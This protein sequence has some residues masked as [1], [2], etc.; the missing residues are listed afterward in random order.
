MSY[1][2]HGTYISSR[3]GKTATTDFG[4]QY[5]SVKKTNPASQ[6]V[7]LSA[8]SP[9]LPNKRFLFIKDVR[10]KSSVKANIA[11]QT[12]K[13]DGVT[14]IEDFGFETEAGEIF[15]FDFFCPLRIPVGGSIKVILNE[16]SQLTGDVF[17]YLH[18]WYEEANVD[19]VVNG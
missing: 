2:D 10:V 4:P 12:F 14:K 3:P 6:E 17:V 16:A 7:L 5:L 19:D 13:A 8:A 11:I 1:S 15:S 18:G 9:G